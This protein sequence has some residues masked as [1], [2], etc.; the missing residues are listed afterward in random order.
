[1]RRDADPTTGG[2]RSSNEFRDIPEPTK[3]SVRVRQRGMRGHETAAG[4][5]FGVPRAAECRIVMPIARLNALSGLH[6]ACYMTNAGRA[7]PSNAASNARDSSLLDR[8]ESRIQ[9][10]E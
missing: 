8:P 9:G 1:M 5:G 4:P 3:R 6:N 10:S 2:I 7:A